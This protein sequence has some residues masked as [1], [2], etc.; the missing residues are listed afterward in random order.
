MKK[1]LKTLLFSII[2]GIA[3]IHGGQCFVVQSIQ[4]AMSFNNT[5]ETVR[6][7]KVDVVEQPQD[8]HSIYKQAIL[9]LSPNTQSENI[10][11]LNYL[12][13]DSQAIKLKQGEIFKIILPQTEESNWD[14]DVPENFLTMQGS[15]KDDKKII[16]EFKAN[17]Q[18]KGMFFMDNI[19]KEGA[20]QSKILRFWIV[21][22]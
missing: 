17:S 10:K 7:E 11:I 12:E 15:Q 5:A 18:G 19:T 13:Y 20:I 3:H 2:A 4:D 9:P 14:I 1:L 16:Y 8:L 6:I 21:K 22:P